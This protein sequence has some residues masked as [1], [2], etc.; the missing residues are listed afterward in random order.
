LVQI[1]STPCTQTPSVYAFHLMSGDQVSQSYK[2]TGKIMFLCILVF[3]LF[4]QQTRRKGFW[5]EW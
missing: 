4:R 3:T 2:T 1:F 5:T